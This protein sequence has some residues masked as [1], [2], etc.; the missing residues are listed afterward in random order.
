MQTDSQPSGFSSDCKPRSIGSSISFADD[1]ICGKGASCIVYENRVG[2]LRVAV[3]R[4]RAEYR[5]EPTHR[6]SYRK[7]FHIG[8]KLKH[9]G[10]PVYRDF[11]DTD[12]EVYIVMEFIDGV[13]LGDFLKTDEGQK[14]FSIADNARRFFSQ[15]LTIV[16]YLHRSGVIHCDIKPANILVRHSDRGVMLIDLDKSYSDVLDSTHGGTRLNS[17]P[18]RHGEKPS[19]SK[20]FHAIGKIIEIIAASVPGFPISRFR[21]LLNRCNDVSATDDTLSEALNSNSKK[22]VLVISLAGLSIILAFTVYILGQKA[23][24]ESGPKS[25]PETVY[26][27]DVIDTVRIDET[28]YD[29]PVKTSATGIT[30]KNSRG[31]LITVSEF[32]AGMTEFINEADVALSVLSSGT[33]SDDWYLDMMG[34]LSISYSSKIYDLIQEY[35]SKYPAVS[36]DKVE[37]DVLMIAEKSQAKSLL[38]QFMEYNFHAGKST[39]YDSVPRSAD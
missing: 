1:K 19:V 10:L 33:A 15:L 36:G 22:S 26:Q 7:E 12:D 6:A 29:S 18:L 34:T 9:D 5:L 39:A 32:D 20:D 17:E 2:G 37:Y 8:Q 24:Q 38:N 11:K 23:P 25:A 3:K 14:Y 4:L 21:K 28:E 27:H 13:T 31:T 30:E 35:K 16:G